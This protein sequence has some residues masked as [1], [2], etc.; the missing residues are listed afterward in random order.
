MVKG[1]NIPTKHG[2]RMFESHPG[3]RCM[4]ALFCT[5]LYKYFYTVTKSERKLE[6][7]SI[8]S[9]SSVSECGPTLQDP[10]SPNNH[11]TV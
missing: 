7:I 4:K 6:K 2:N 1:V 3:Q 8:S 5:I 11:P 10:Y 9:S